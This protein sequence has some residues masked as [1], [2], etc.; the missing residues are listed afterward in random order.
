MKSIKI[1][2]DIMHSPLWY[3]DNNKINT[4]S[5]GVE[6]IDNNDE[7]KYICD[8]LSKKYDSYYGFNTHDLP[9]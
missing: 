4:E 8:E 3:Y 5:I 6:D 9:C 1:M 7:L 2:F